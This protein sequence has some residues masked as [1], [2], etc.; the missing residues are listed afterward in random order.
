MENNMKNEQLKVFIRVDGGLQLG[1]G[2][3]VR[4]V[5]LGHM[6]QEEY[7]VHFFSKEIPEKFADQ[8]TSAGFHFTKINSEEDF[9]KISGKAEIVVLDLL[10]LTPAIQKEIKNNGSKVVVVD[11]LHSG[12]FSADLIINHAPGIIASDY[13]ADY[14]CQFALGL[15]F[16]LLRPGFLKEASSKLKASTNLENLFICFGGSDSLNLTRRSL[17]VALSHPF[18]KSINVVVGNSYSSL[19]DLKRFSALHDKVHIYHNIREEEMIKVMRDSGLAIVPA[20]GVLLE[21]LTMGLSAISGMYVPNQKFFYQNYKKKNLIID[22]NNFSKVAISSA[23][24]IALKGSSQRTNAIDGQSG[25]RIL[26]FFRGLT[27]EDQVDL[28]RANPED[29]DITFK[30]ATSPTVRAF[31]FSQEEIHYKEHEKWFFQK[32]ASQETL[33][34]A[35]KFNNTLVGSVRFDNIKTKPV[36]SYL[37]DPDYHGWGLGSIILKKGVKM[38]KEAYPATEKVTGKVLPENIPSIK[39]FDRLGY[40]RIMINGKFYEFTKKL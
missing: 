32:L 5:A 9:L 2:H 8:I 35:A 33:Y 34:L 38:L 14:T 6:V 16:A 17:E 23:L 7:E 26:K 20:S 13:D 10:N 29:V 22:A 40:N 37:I 28:Q 12:K 27:L 31:A 21:A 18:F 4:C 39:I 15:D 25:S 19:E 24:E 30:W 3:L 36:I 11:D 1:L